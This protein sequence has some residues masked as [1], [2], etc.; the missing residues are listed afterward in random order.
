MERVMSVAEEKQFGFF[1][2]VFQVLGT[3]EIFLEKVK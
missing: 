1:F 3:L 2:P